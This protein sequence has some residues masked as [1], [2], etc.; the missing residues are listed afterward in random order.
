M[1][2]GGDS[3]RPAGSR[4]VHTKHQIANDFQKKF[5]S[6]REGSPCILVG[7]AVVTSRNRED[8]NC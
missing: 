4:S 2:D 6:E 5:H 8:E 7:S 3:V 1:T